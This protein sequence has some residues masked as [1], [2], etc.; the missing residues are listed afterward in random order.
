MQDALIY[1]QASGDQVEQLRVHTLVATASGRYDFAN[2]NL[3]N[4]VDVTPT[5][6]G[7]WLRAAW[8]APPSTGA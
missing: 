4:M 5:R 3:N 1:A 7:Q 2:A 8:G 6:F